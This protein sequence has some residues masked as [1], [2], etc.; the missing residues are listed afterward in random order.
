MEGA[1]PRLHLCAAATHPPLDPR[2]FSGLSAHLF[3]TLASSGAAIQPL[4]TRD[5]NAREMLRGAVDVRPLLRGRRPRV[6]AAWQWSRR[7]SVRQ[8]ALASARAARLDVDAILQVGTHARLMHP[9]AIRSCITDATVMQAIAAGEFTVSASG[10]AE[11]A[12]AW[13]REV[14][15]SMDRI[16]TL[17]AWAARSV[18]DDY[19]IPAERVVVTGAGANLDAPAVRT[20]GPPMILFVGRDWEQK[21]GPAILAAFRHARYIVPDL[22]LVIVGC[23]PAINEPGV[24][25]VGPL[26][27]R[28]PEQYDELR[29]LYGRAT[30]FALCSRFDAFPNVLLEAQWSGVPVVAYDEASRPE[31][32]INGETGILVP[33]DNPL[34]LVD[35][36]LT[37]ATDRRLG[38][39]MGFAGHAHVGRDFSWPTVG[40]RILRELWELRTDGRGIR[41]SVAAGTAR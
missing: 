10:R 21:G 31:A 22:E 41:S 15:E 38:E 35:A 8:S 30:M 17:S 26:D 1:R 16:F 32:V 33:R 7:T 37:L 27:R 2:T 14:F 34:A 12:V 39:R 4:V 20:H 28:I 11:E 19:G 36:F 29:A 6:R 24:R 3:A 13:Q 18:V 23:T 40:E 5:V 9:R 25:V